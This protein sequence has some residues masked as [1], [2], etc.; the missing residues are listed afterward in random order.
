MYTYWRTEE[1]RVVSLFLLTEG[2]TILS[3]PDLRQANRLTFFFDALESKRDAVGI[4]RE[5]LLPSRTE[6]FGSEA[7]GVGLSRAEQVCCSL[8]MQSIAKAPTDADVSTSSDLGKQHVNIII[9]A[10]PFVQVIQGFLPQAMSQ[11]V[12]YP[13][14]SLRVCP[15]SRLV[16]LTHKKLIDQRRKGCFVFQNSFNRSF[17]LANVACGLLQPFANC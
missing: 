11:E 6:G 4:G 3:T 8:R 2:S 13:L 1:K 7:M 14:R 12:T 9:D 17:P 5:F 15:T 16:L 10:P